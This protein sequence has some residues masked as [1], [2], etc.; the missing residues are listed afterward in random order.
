[1]LNSVKEL[2]IRFRRYIENKSFRLPE[3]YSHY[4]AAAAQILEHLVSIQTQCQFLANTYW[5]NLAMQSIKRLNASAQ[6]SV[7]VTFI[8]K[9]NT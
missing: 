8:V 7:W 2:R 5:F 6:Y 3:P 4:S 1:M 9:K